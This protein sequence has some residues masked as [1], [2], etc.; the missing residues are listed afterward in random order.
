MHT[1]YEPQIRARLGT[2]AHFCEVAI[3]KFEYG[4]ATQL[5]QGTDFEAWGFP[6]EGNRGQWIF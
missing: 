2:A 4:E 5:N 3:L 6:L 1:V